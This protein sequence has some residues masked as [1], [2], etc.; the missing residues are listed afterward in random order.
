MPGSVTSVFSEPEDFGAALREEGWLGFLVTGHG[1]FRAQLTQIALQ[2]IRISAADEQLSRVAFIAVP[3]GMISVSFPIGHGSLPFY[4]GARMQVGEIMILTP[5]K[6]LHTRTEGI[7]RWGAV[8][9]PVE[10]LVDYGRALTGRPFGIP[11]TL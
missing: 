10:E 3:P 5:G 4:G 9:I 11:V 7:C 1:H 6:H 8:C 2:R